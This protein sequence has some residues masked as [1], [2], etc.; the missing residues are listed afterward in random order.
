MPSGKRFS[1]TWSLTVLFNASW[2]TRSQISQW[3]LRRIS[4]LEADLLKRITIN[5]NDLTRLNHEELDQLE[6][7]CVKLMVPP[8]ERQLSVA[9]DDEGSDGRV[10]RRIEILSILSR[11]EASLISGRN[12]ALHLL[13]GLKAA[14]AAAEDDARTV[15]A[16]PANGRLPKP[17]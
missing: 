1:L 8:E 12:K 3:R 7:I 10:P 13:Y 15:W 9:V 6:K 2:L 4:V 16:S 17:Q 11:Y 5:T 14:S